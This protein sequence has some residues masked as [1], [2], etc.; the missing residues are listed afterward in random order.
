MSFAHVVSEAN[1]NATL[2][3][4]SQLPRRNLPDFAIKSIKIYEPSLKQLN[5]V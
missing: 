4:T 3:S 2:F 5:S 1:R